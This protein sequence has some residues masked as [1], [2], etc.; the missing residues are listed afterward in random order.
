[1]RSDRYPFPAIDPTSGASFEVFV[2]DRKAAATAKRGQGAVLE[3]ANC[4][5]HVL[6]KPLAIFEGI[7]WDADEDNFSDCDSW[8]CYCGVPP[9]LYYPNETRPRPPKPDEVFLVFVNSD[10]V[11]YHWRWEKADKDGTGLPNGY[12]TRFRKKALP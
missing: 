4:V 6:N 10:R 5:K 11:A 12:L 9:H 2:T 7:R 3:M 8:L 1:M